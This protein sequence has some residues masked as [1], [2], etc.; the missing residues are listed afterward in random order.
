MKI[1]IKLIFGILCTRDK[2]KAHILK[3]K[4]LRY[5]ITFVEEGTGKFLFTMHSVHKECTSN[6][7]DLR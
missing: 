5:D 1:K 4:L 7:S 6:H 3:I 2:K